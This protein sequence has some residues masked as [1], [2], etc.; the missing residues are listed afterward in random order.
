MFQWLGMLGTLAPLI[1]THLVITVPI[2]VW[3]MIGYFE[4]LPVDLEEAAL[5]DGATSGRRSATSRCRWRG[6]ASWSA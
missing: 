1:I 3:I 6:P 5:V 2:V 4:G